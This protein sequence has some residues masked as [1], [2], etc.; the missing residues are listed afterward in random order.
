MWGT[1]RDRGAPDGSPRCVA[2]V[3]SPGV[4][5]PAG[6]GPTLEGAHATRCD[7]H[8]RPASSGGAFP[9]GPGSLLEGVARAPVVPGALLAPSGRCARDGPTCHVARLL[10]P[11]CPALTVAW[12]PLHDHRGG[13]TPWS[14][15]STRTGYP[16]P[17]R[18]TRTGPTPSDGWDGP[19]SNPPPTACHRA[20][21][22]RT[23]HRRSAG[24]P[25]PSTRQ[26]AAGRADHRCWGCDPPVECT[27]HLEEARPT[28]GPAL[29]AFF[30]RCR[31]PRALRRR[32]PPRRSTRSG[33]SPTTRTGNRPGTT[34]HC[35][36][37]TTSRR[38]RPGS[39]C[40]RG[41]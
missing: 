24:R 31:C 16:T 2:R 13:P 39:R 9:F 12:G 7:R 21:G 4:R 36:T 6:P 27:R 15:G 40:S 1:H 34:R 26:P 18:R 33:S 5:S 3:A 19:G 37:A 8:H 20:T 10:P 14:H 25:G 32:Q 29:S 38:S 22:S 28:G 30:S 17:R 11:S 41:T 23:D 35:W